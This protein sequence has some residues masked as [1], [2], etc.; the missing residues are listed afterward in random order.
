MATLIKRTRGGSRMFE[1]RFSADGQRKTIPLGKKYTEKTAGELR[2]VVEHLI[3]CQD[4]GIEQPGKKTLA[5][6]QE[7]ST[8]IR[9]KL[10]RFG[11]I[12]QPPRKTTGELWTEFRNEK[13]GIK[14]TT[15]EGYDHAER[16][17]FLFFGADEPLSE[18]TQARMNQWKAYLRKEGGLAESTTAGTLTKAKAVFNWAVNVGWIDAS[19]LDGVGRGSFINRDNDRFITMD[20]YRRLLDACPCQDWRTIIALARIGGLRAPSEVL[21]LRWEDILWNRNRFWITSSKTEHHR[22]KEGRWCKLFAGLRAELSELFFRGESE[23]K[24]FV[25][26]RYRDPE[27][28]NLG[29]QFARIVK[30]AGIEPILRPFDNMRAS[31]STEVYAEYG[32]FLE[33][34]WIGHSTKIAH[35]HYLQ[36]RDEDFDRP[37]GD[38]TGGKIGWK[39][40]FPPPEQQ[41][42]PL[43]PPEQGGK[44]LHG[45]EGVQRANSRQT[46]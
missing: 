12:V 31:R 11:L 24:V 8:E 16:R 3:H 42:P 46:L 4:N 35:A 1:I 7:A 25:I 6:I 41:F 26:T 44:S 32:A 21:R 13:H 19:P 30:M 38:A 29:T 23:G 27:R 36:V 5:W 33:S 45:V 10:A 9:D 28:T 18:L 40:A 22:G 17:F 20:E 37:E 34:Q 15:L 2:E 39:D 14:E 43:F